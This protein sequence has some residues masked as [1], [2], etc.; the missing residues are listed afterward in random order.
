MRSRDP[1]VDR[2]LLGG[3]LVAAFAASSVTD[4]RLLAGALLA[5]L[6]VSVRGPWPVR[7][8]L[9][10]VLPLSAGLSLASWG[11]L[12][13]LGARPPI[14]PFAALVLRTVLIAFVGFAVLARVDL[15]RALAP[16]PLASRLLVVTLAQI[17]ALRRLRTESLL[18]LRSR[19]ARRPGPI[20]VARSAGVVTATLFGV[21]SRNAQDVADAI[22]SRGF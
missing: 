3:W 17:H 15:L 8:T 12:R 10:T 18:G 19:L 7:R 21:A 11:W 22:R 5:A 16:W 6:L 13:L 20:D 2:L 14:G 1:R 4:W 9:V